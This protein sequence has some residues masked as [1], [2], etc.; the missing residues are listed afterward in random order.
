VTADL[1]PT[2]PVSAAMPAS[3]IRG[4]AMIAGQWLP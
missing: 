2:L 4:D 3:G 1:P